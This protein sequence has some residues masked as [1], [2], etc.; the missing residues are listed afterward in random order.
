MNVLQ[1]AARANAEN[2]PEVNGMDSGR[3]RGR[4]GH[5]NANVADPAGLDLRWQ[6]ATLPELLAIMDEL[7]NRPRVWSAD[8]DG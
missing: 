4:V 3:S 8:A 7:Q 2:A 5:H 1:R 6:T